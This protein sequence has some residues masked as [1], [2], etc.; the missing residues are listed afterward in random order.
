MFQNLFKPLIPAEMLFDLIL[1][2]DR[3]AHRRDDA[4][5]TKRT[6][7]RPQ[8]RPGR[9]FADSRLARVRVVAREPDGLN[10]VRHTMPPGAVRA[11]RG[12]ARNG[13]LVD[14]PER[15]KRLPG[16]LEFADDPLDRAAG[17][18]L[19]IVRVNDDRIQMPQIEEDVL[20]D[21]DIAPRMETTNSPD[22]PPAMPAEDVQQL[23]FAPRRVAHR[24]PKG[25]VAAEVRDRGIRHPRASSPN[26]S[27]STRCPLVMCRCAGR[28]DGGGRSAARSPSRRPAA[29][30]T[31]DSGVL[32]MR[33][34]LILIALLLGVAIAPAADREVKI[35]TTVDDNRFKD[36]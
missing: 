29:R 28:R 5:A 4:E 3:Q 24:G 14:Q 33:P 18:D 13:L 26:G 9:D 22:S 8:F 36:I 34:R 32:S 27:D 21:G 11:R 12:R 30:L 15:R 2:P 19:D 16:P 17:A 6:A 35:G 31:R 20:A 25:C 1:Q 23:R 10:V 7:S